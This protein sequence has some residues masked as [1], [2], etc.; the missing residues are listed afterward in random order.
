[1]NSSSQYSTLPGA[2]ASD[3]Y[4]DRD[5]TPL[6]L[7]IDTNDVS[8]TSDVNQAPISKT[9]LG[10]HQQLTL[11]PMLQVKDTV[12]HL[13][14]AQPAPAEAH[15]AAPFGRSQRRPVAKRPWAET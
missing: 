6:D 14:M 5:G 7:A 9:C 15:V 11:T 12:E 2:C 3:F 1:M 4:R 13:G 10:H 8:S